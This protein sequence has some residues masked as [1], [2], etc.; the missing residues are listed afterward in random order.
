VARKPRSKRS[1][2]RPGG[3]PPAETPHARRIRQYLEKHPGAT[4]AEA[5]GHRPG[6]H[7]TREER[8]RALR[9]LTEKERAAIMRYAR[10]NARRTGRQVQE[11]YR[12]MVDWAQREE[13][14][15]FK[16]FD[17]MR[18][19]RDRLTKR[20]PTDVRIRMR[21]GVATLVGDTRGQARNLEAMDE[22][23]EDYDVPDIEWLYYH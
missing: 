11:T 8:A 22:F 16:D 18:K 20:G 12:D 17:R 1:R 23:L 2:R 21:K 7:R 15:G 4:K 10:A 14:D 9:R 5:R 6:E 19:L 3:S 13:G